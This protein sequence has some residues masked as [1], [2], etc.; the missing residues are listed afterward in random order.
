MCAAAEKLLEEKE[1]E[2]GIIPDPAVDTYMRAMGQGYRLAADIAVKALGLEG[3]ANTLVVRGQGSGQG[4]TWQVAGRGLAGPGMES[5]RRSAG[6]QGKLADG[7]CRL[8][9][10]RATP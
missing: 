6:G 1:Q 7:A 2:L 4:S 10:C 8:P 3:C 5:S 9:C